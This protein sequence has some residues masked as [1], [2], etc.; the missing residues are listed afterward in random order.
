MA[1]INPLHPNSDHY[2]TSPYDILSSCSI[3]GMRIQEM[4]SRDPSSQLLSWTISMAIINP[5]H[6]NSDHHLTSPYDI[7]SSCSIQGMRIQEMISRDP[8]SQRFLQILPSC[9]VQY[10][11][12][13]GRIETLILGMKGLTV[14]QCHSHTD[15]FKLKSNSGT[16]TILNT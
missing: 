8:S 2:L 3:Q 12:I 11:W 14:L 6:P 10:M 9:D 7:L 16:L 13:V 4:I 5:L 1:I 15:R